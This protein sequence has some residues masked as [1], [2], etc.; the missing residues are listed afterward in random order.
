MQLEKVY[1]VFFLSADR[2]DFSFAKV[3]VDVWKYLDKVR[4]ASCRRVEE[5]L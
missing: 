2:G 5:K 1:P 3:G 4:R